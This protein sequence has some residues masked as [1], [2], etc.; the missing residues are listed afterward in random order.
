[1]RWLLISYVRYEYLF[2]KSLN[3]SPLND[4]RLGMTH[5]RVA[6]KRQGRVD[7]ARALIVAHGREDRRR[8]GEIA[9]GLVLHARYLALLYLRMYAVE[10]A[11]DLDDSTVRT[12][13]AHRGTI[14]PRLLF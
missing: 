14:A 2:P 6:I 1:M 10:G 8:A 12:L 11:H 4:K 5:A 9:H 13:D 3:A 7:V